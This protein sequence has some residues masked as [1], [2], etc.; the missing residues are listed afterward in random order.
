MVSKTKL[1]KWTLLQLAEQI[2]GFWKILITIISKCTFLLSEI[3]RNKIRMKQL[4]FMFYTCEFCSRSIFIIHDFVL[5]QILG[6]S[7]LKMEVEVPVD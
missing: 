4:S 7:G 6:N 5:Y 2:L 3:V 1:F